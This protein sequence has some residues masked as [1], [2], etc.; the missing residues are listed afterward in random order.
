MD[1]ATEV[2]HRP[3][4]TILFAVTIT[5]ILSNSLIS[6]AIPDILD[7]FDQPDSR[8]GILVAA[9]S[10]PGIVVAPLVGFAAD[11]FGR[12]RVLLPCLFFFGSF[13]VASAAAPTFNMLLAARFGMGFGASGLINLAIVMIADNWSGTERTRLIGLNSAV[14]TMGLAVLPLLSGL[15]T[16]TVSWRAALAVYSVALAT[17]AAVAVSID[18]FKP[19]QT[20]GATA[21][22]RDAVTVLRQPILVA[23]LASVV[24]TFILIFGVFLATL[25]IHLEQ[26]FGLGA[27]WRGAIIA[28]PALSSSIVSANLATLR[29]RL[30][31]RTIL[32]VGTSLFAMSFFLLGSAGVLLFVVIAAVVYGVGEGAMIPSLQDAAMTIAPAAHR[33]G[34]LAVWVGFARLG[35]SIGP[36]LATAMI[37]STSTSATIVAGGGAGLLLVVLKLFGPIDDRAVAA[38]TPE[39]V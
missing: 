23:T 36:L 9:G 6:P 26:E 24:L 31:L 8:A 12:K 18:N 16:E 21:Q 25:P 22:I 30:G 4:I 2:S 27:G 13:G 32:V 38:A 20:G 17:A 14:L 5:G 29:D 33:G 10:L 37:A 28:V 19:E 39:E 7:H 11:R 3:P 35:Q 34:V 15:L 1:Q